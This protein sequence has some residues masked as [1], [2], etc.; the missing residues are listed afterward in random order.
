MKENPD[1]SSQN[2]SGWKTTSSDEVYTSKWLS[3][4]HDKILRPD[5]SSGSYDVVDTPDFVIAVAKQEG[6]FYLVGQHRHPVNTFS[7]EFPKGKL[8][9]GESP[10]E[11]AL[12]ELEEE[13][14]V[15][16]HRA[17]LIASLWPSNG[18]QSNSFHIC[19]AEDLIEGTQRLDAT[20]GD[21]EVMRANRLTMEEMILKGE[22]RDSTTISA[23]LLYESYTRRRATIYLPFPLEL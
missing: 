11:G 17:I 9:K 1:A 5:G 8:E 13:T 16:A 10:E 4:R 15:K 18:R 22:I 12:R 23:L 2:G 3:V 21:L 6:Q 20:E 7:W 14:G 19:L